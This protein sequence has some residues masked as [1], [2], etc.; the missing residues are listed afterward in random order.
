[1]LIHF[2]WG[3]VLLLLPSRASYNLFVGQS[4]VTRIHFFPVK[5]IEGKFFLIDLNKQ[6][7]KCEMNFYLLRSRRAFS[8]VFLCKW[9]R[10]SPLISEIW[11]VPYTLALGLHLLSLSGTTQTNQGNVWRCKKKEKRKS[12]GVPSAVSRSRIGTARW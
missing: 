2:S 9:W 4:H 11:R 5:K 3:V 7:I 12:L 1:M 10:E 6:K 8:C